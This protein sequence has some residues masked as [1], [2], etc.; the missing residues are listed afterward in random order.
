MSALGGKQTLAHACD[1]PYQG[2]MDKVQWLCAVAFVLLLG[3]SLYNLRTGSVTAG[4]WTFSRQQ[5]PFGFY[6]TVLAIFGA[7]AMAILTVWVISRPQ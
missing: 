1:V 3:G 7:S 2:R 5:R 6:A 4:P